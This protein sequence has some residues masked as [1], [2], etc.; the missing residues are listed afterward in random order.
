MGVEDARRKEGRDGRKRNV[1]RTQGKEKGKN[2]FAT[3]ERHLILL[4]I[5]W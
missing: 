3:C 1:K 5:L 2:M 4:V